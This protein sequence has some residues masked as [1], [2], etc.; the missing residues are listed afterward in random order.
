MEKP[1]RICWNE[2]GKHWQAFATSCCCCHYSEL[3]L[4]GNADWFEFCAKL[5][6]YVTEEKSAE[7]KNG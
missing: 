1:I 2:T 7:V 4:F 3:L 6:A 5:K